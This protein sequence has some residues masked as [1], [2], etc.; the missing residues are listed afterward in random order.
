[1]QVATMTMVMTMVSFMEIS[2]TQFKAKCLRLMDEVA[3]SGEPLVITKHGKPIVTVTAAKPV[4]KPLFGA[5]AGSIDIVGDIL[6]PISTQWDA[7][8]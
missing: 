8:R 6:Q 5:D 4:P 7:A 3:Q 1:M 2:A